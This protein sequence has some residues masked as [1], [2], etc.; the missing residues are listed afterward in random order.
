MIFLYIC[1]T[2]FLTKMQGKV[3]GIGETIMDILFKD[4]QPVSAVAGGS[5]YNSI[6]SLGRIDIPCCFV[7]YSGDDITGRNLRQFLS[8]NGVSTEYYHLRADE[9][10]AI[11][12]AYLGENSDAEYIFYKS[13]PFLHEGTKLPNVGSHDIVL[14]SSYFSISEGTH[15]KVRELLD[16][17]EKSAASVYYDVNFRRTHAHEVKALMPAIRHN[18]SKSS[19]VRG[20]SDDLEIMFGTRDPIEIYWKYVAPLCPIFICTSGP[21]DI[22]VCTPHDILSFPA[23]QIANVVSTIGAGDSF[24]AGIVY[25]MIHDEIGKNSLRNLTNTEWKAIISC[26]AGFAVD[27]CQSTENYVSKQFANCLKS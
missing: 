10:S 20:S 16:K 19:I 3:I 2:Q 12:L 18:M 13:S 21:D 7:G 27:A 26:A 9:S 8:E 5:C 4:G 14:M 22:I 6:V 25:A 11:S 1:S 17:A 15:S 24:N 23:P